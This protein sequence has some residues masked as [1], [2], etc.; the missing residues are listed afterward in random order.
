[1]T[2]VP[3]DYEWYDPRGDESVN[4]SD[5]IIEDEFSS[6]EE[7]RGDGEYVPDG[8]EGYKEYEGSKRDAD[9]RIELLCKNQGPT[10]EE[11]LQ[12]KARGRPKTAMQP[13]HPMNFSDA[14][15]LNATTQPTTLGRGGKTIREGRG[16]RGCGSST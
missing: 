3:Y 4:L 10:V 1:M 5:I 7:P 12:K 16:A 2:P 15:H 11:P 6:D 8:D 9:E 13:T 14:G